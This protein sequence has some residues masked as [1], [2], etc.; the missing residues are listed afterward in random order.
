MRLGARLLGAMAVVAALATTGCD[1]D[2]E[3]PPV[4]PPPEDAGEVE[5]AG[6]DAGIDAGIDAGFDGGVDA[7]TD[8]GAGF[9]PAGWETPGSATFH[10]PSANL[11]LSACTGCHGLDLTG[12]AVGVSCDQCHGGWKTNCVFC[13]GG[14]DNPT[15]APPAAVDGRT[16]TTEVAVGAHSSHMMAP[17]ALSVPRDCA[18]CHAK[19][20]DA[21]TPGHIDPRPAE[22]TLPGWVPASAS[23]ATYCHGQF[24][25][26]TAANTPLW[27]V[28]NGTQAPCGS[29]HALPP[30]TGRHPATFAP[31]AFMGLNCTTCHPDANGTASAILQPALH[32]N[33]IKDVS[34]VGGT[35]DGTTRTC[36]PACHGP[37]TW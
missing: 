15:G 36:T 16:A 17:R 29:C 18:D 8:A 19:P 33:G 20:A 37:E 21:L 13:H 14:T 11:G 32:I 27:T 34:P 6:F 2:E 9:H 24:T 5:D 7:G 31:H 4:E 10:G 3:P 23:C 25:G 12:G 35:W 22:V 28:V 1:G 26:G 30:S